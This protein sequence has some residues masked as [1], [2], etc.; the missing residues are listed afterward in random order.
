MKC[1]AS[2]DC[3]PRVVQFHVTVLAPMPTEC[4]ST[5]EVPAYLSSVAWTPPDRL[6]GVSNQRVDHGRRTG[7]GPQ[8][9]RLKRGEAAKKV[10]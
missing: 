9:Q 2:A 7:C 10:C 3:V 8:I 6:G 1:E 4:I 5:S